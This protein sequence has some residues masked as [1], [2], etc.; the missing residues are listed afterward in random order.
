MDK[1]APYKE[2]KSNQCS[3]PKYVNIYLKNLISKRNYMHRKWKRP[4]SDLRNFKGAR[5]KVAKALKKLKRNYYSKR[6]ERC[7]NHPKQTY[8]LLNELQGKSDRK[9]IKIEQIKLLKT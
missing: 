8:K 2:L 1:F 5:L 6:L 3:K 4:S 9:Q 7:S